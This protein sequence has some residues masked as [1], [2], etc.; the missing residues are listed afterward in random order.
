M[1]EKREGKQFMD[2][3]TVSNGETR[4]RLNDNREEPTK[5]GDSKKKSKDDIAPLTFPKIKPF[6]GV[7]AYLSS[8][9]NEREPKRYPAWDAAR[10]TVLVDLF[11]AK[12]EERSSE[13]RLSEIRHLSV[14]RRQSF[15]EQYK[16]LEES[17][18]IFQQSFRKFN[19]FIRENQEKRER[20]EKKIVDEQ[21]LQEKREE[22]INTVEK[23]IVYLTDIKGTMDH[24]IKEY[25]MYEDYLQ[26][27]VKL[28]GGFKNVSDII[29]RYE[30][31]TEAKHFLGE[32]QE[33]QLA[34]LENART[35]LSKLLEEK[36]LVLI[37]LNNQLLEL[38]GRYENA[39]CDSLL[40]ETLVSRIQDVSIQRIADLKS[41]R[42]TAWQIYQDMCAR[43]GM[44]SGCDRHA[45]ED[46]LVFIKKTVSEL[47]R[48][49]NMAKN[50][51][52][53]NVDS[54]AGELGSAKRNLGRHK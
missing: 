33:R 3:L 17:E 26:S 54:M 36:S 49:L 53:K 14:D 9:L 31:L 34:L 32:R 1:G 13:R 12:R 18:A 41:V 29:Q 50:V 39:K 22:D 4:V 19:K 43:K 21:N 16:E 44:R 6:D 42:T 35:E 45:V 52:A 37:G 2:R 5:A 8:K 28:S 23:N 15:N 30:A 24:Q 51:H 25:R 11:A 10:E 48:V 20:A 38:Q 47:G 27:V 40:W 7:G 46:Q